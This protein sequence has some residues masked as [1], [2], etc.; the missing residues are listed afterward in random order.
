MSQLFAADLSD[1]LGQT[2]ISSYSLPQNQV[3][4]QQP[5][6]GNFFDPAE[7]AC[8]ASSNPTVAL[9]LLAAMAS[10]VAMATFIYGSHFIA[11][12]VTG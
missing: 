2:I 6:P 8:D 9:V 3:T 10:S 5:L 4:N 12:L 7:C 1:P 11:T